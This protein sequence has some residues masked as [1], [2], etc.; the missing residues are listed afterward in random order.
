MYGIVN[1]SPILLLWHCV[2]V[3][4]KGPPM[5]CREIPLLEISLPADMVRRGYAGESIDSE[6]IL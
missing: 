5:S 3:V 6:V 4:I 2:A 1:C